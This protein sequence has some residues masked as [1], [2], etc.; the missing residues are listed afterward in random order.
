MRDALSPAAGNSFDVGL[1]G[2]LLLVVAVLSFTRAAQRLVEQAWELPSLSIRNSLNGLLWIAGLGGYVLVTGWIHALFGGGPLEL[3]ANTL[4]APVAI[5]FLTWSGWL[6]S[7]KR[8]PWERLLPFAVIAALLLSLYGI[9]ADVYVPHLFSSYATRYGV[10]GAAFAMIAALF[11]VMLALVA[12]AAAGR[13]FSDELDR[14]RRGERPPDDEV[15]REWDAVVAE[16]R[17]HWQAVRKQ[18][19]SLGRAGSRSK[20]RPSR[21]SE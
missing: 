19:H 21:N 18:A 20:S 14:V 4:V 2:L 16:A 6:L 11:G 17:S 3:V 8:L 9:A 15:R 13:E 7:G 12:A 1:F 10:I 5:V